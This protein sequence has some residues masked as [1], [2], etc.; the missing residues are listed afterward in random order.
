MDARTK[1]RKTKQFAKKSSLERQILQEIEALLMGKKELALKD[2]DAEHSP[3][4]R[5]TLGSVS[6]SQ[7]DTDILTEHNRLRK[8]EAITETASYMFKMAHHEGL[9][10]MAQTVSNTCIFEHST[11]RSHPDF[12]WIGENLYVTNSTSATVESVVQSWYNEKANFSYTHN[13]CSDVCGHYTQVVWADSKYLGC[14]IKFCSSVFIPSSSKTMSNA[15]MV[16]CHY[17]PGG[18]YNNKLPYEV[19][20]TT[21]EECPNNCT[22]TA[23]CETDFE[24]QVCEDQYSNCADFLAYCSHPT[25]I[26]GCPVACNLCSKKK[27]RGINN[28]SPQRDLIEALLENC[29]MNKASRKLISRREKV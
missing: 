18:N 16:T 22:D 27:K 15:H 29:K 4:K 3:Q 1:E 17:G 12:S 8:E 25:I 6:N 2:A 24:I 20:S 5:T 9:A 28:G 19:G 7:F 21:C 23:L 10:E 14:G 11:G 13:N 26:E